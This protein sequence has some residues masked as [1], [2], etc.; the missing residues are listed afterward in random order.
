VLQQLLAAKECGA[1]VAFLEAV[2]SKDEVLKAIELL[3]PMPVSTGGPRGRH[4]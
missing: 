1:D 2:S 3:S 4:I